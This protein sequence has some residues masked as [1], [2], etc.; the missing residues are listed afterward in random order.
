MTLT[1]KPYR[2]GNIGQRQ[3]GVDKQRA[4]LAHS[5]S[6]HTT[7]ERHSRTRAEGFSEVVLTQTSNARNLICCQIEVEISFNVIDNLLSLGP[8]KTS[9]ALAELQL[10][11]GIALYE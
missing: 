4:R 8:R 2:G 11:D 1:G 10:P 5:P 3:V 6:Q 7:V 9:L